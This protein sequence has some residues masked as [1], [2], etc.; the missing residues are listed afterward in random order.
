MAETFDW[1]KPSILWQ[2]ASADMLREDFFRPE[3]LEFATD[4]F[5]E[6]FLSAA[7]ASRPDAFTQSVAR[8]LRPNQ[9]LKLFQPVHGRFYLTSASLCCRLP[10]FPDREVQLGEGE[11]VFFLLRK[12]VAGV[13]YAWNK[14][15]D[16][17]GWQSLAS[18]NGAVLP[19]EERLPLF[20]TT[21]AKSRALFFG[22]IPV[23]SQDTYAAAPT[24][25]I[26]DS[27]R[28]PRLD[29][30]DARFILPLKN[31]GSLFGKT[32]AGAPLRISV[33]LLL[34][35]WEYL[36]TYLPDVAAALRDNTTATLTGK[37]RDL[38]NYL[39]TKALGGSLNLATA[40]RQVALKQE[41][42]N[43]PGDSDPSA[44]GFNDDFNLNTHPFTDT[45]LDQL[46]N[47]VREALGDTPAPPPI[48][49]PKFAPGAGERYV[50]RCVYE[51]AQC[52]P[53]NRYISRPTQEFELAPF[54]D[55]DAPARNI[56]IG[57]PVDVSIAGLRKFKKNVAFMT[58]KELRNKVQSVGPGM[59]KGDPAG[60]E[61]TLN[62]GEICSFSIP[63]ITL[64]AFILLMIIAILLNIVFWWLPLL[65]IC[66]PLKLAA[67][68]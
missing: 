42:L 14:S 34:D 24:E 11:S 51:R 53:P 26:V 68:N 46:S 40:L 61:G 3:L 15:E 2:P 60:P 29:E 38:T 36:N 56:R 52:D 5:M 37:K 27:S 35:L 48:P 54:F 67:K 44:L 9:T 12:K 18:R 20:Q 39:Q 59:L 65:K 43:Q 1:V 21:T 57:M 19:N 17:K 58:S 31:A 6:D 55:P 33:Y 66:F 63:I 7:A 16:T 47:A 45:V 30:L 41:Q 50:L 23:S 49:V 22:Y 28:D 4:K 25:S 32:P 13:E 10:G 8:P 62:I 64:I